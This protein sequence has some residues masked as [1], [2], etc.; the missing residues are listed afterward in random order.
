[1]GTEHKPPP[2]ICPPFHECRTSVFTCVLSFPQP[3]AWTMFLLRNCAV[4]AWCPLAVCPCVCMQTSNRCMTEVSIAIHYCSF[5]IRDLSAP[6]YKSLLSCT[7]VPTSWTYT[8][9]YMDDICVVS[10]DPS[11][12]QLANKSL[13][14]RHSS[15]AH[16]TAAQQWRANTTQPCATQPALHSSAYR[17]DSR[18]N[19]AQEVSVMGDSNDG[20]LEFHQSFF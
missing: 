7:H 10:F 8:T 18:R 6:A 13:A 15:N 19:F 4:L 1:M 2:G 14:C 5:C 9:P 11:L 20:A 17:D 3:L 16:T 12:G